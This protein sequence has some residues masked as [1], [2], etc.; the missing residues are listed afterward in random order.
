[1]DWL[2]PVVLVRYISIIRN[3]HSDSQEH[4]EGE[5]EMNESLVLYLTGSGS[6]VGA[7]RKL[8]MAYFCVNI[9]FCR[10]FSSAS[11]CDIANAS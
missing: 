2:F 6:L 5:V 7:E 1:M 9:F 10:S 8:D 11:L 3:N 4:S